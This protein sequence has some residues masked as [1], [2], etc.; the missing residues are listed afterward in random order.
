MLP[1]GE[2]SPGKVL[3]DVLP[4]KPLPPPVGVPIIPAVPAEP[5]INGN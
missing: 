3:A 4:K 5:P 2:P 1:T